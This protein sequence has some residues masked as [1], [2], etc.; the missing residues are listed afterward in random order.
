V[1][2]SELT[3]SQF[4]SNYDL[5]NFHPH[6]YD[7]CSA[8]GMTEEEMLAKAIAESMKDQSPSAKSGGDMAGEQAGG[9][10]EQLQAALAQAN[11]TEDEMIARA[12]DPYFHAEQEWDDVAA[13]PTE[14]DKKKSLKK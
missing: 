2:T 7:F 13:S 5:C 6:S 12:S 10:V 9:S 11:L 8:E 1:G 4:T 3:P 14:A